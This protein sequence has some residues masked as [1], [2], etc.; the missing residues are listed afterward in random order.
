MELCGTYAQAS[1]SFVSAKPTLVVIDPVLIDGDGLDLVRAAKASA[2]V[3]LTSAFPTGVAS[4]AR[5]LEVPLVTKPFETDAL[6]A[7]VEKS[8]TT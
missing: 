4:A 1:S 7:L 5:D 6:M 8:V 2:R 3:I